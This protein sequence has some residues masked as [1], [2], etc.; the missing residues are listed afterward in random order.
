[1]LSL[2]I[3][4]S[5]IAFPFNNFANILNFITS[6]KLLDL[7]TLKVGLKKIISIP[8]FFFD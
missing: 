6:K 4:P 8:C 3:P 5:A 7:L 2:L 1:M